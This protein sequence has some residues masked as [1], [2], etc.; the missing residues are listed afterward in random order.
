M[1][2][3][4]GWSDS[5]NFIPILVLLHNCHRKLFSVAGGYLPAQKAWVSHFK[6]NLKKN[7][8]LSLFSKGKY[9]FSV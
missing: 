7:F 8:L 4:G 1:N 6:K 2:K 9:Q 3:W 5:I